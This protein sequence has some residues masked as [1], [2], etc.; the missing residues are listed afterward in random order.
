MGVQITNMYSAFGEATDKIVNGKKSVFQLADCCLQ[1]VIA[2]DVS[3]SH[4]LAATSCPDAIAPSLGQCL[5]QAYNNVFHS[6]H[7]IDIVQGCAG[8][9]SAMILAS[10]LAEANRSNVVVITSDA[11]Q[12]ATSTAS[13]VYHVF[14]NGVFGCCLSYSNSNKRLIHHQSRQYK[15]LYEVVTI[16]LGHDSDAIISDNIE[17]MSSDPRKHLGLKLNNMLAL[18]LMRNAEDFYIDFTKTTGHPDI[19]ILHQ[20]NE[21]LI[22]HLENVF[23]KYPVRFINMAA[24][25]GNCGCATTGIV[26]NSI[27]DKI[28]NKKVMLC[29]FGTGGVITAGLWQC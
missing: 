25:T 18:K 23:S 8:G 22:K 21:V 7:T 24:E 3:Y 16:G 12:K 5:N 6:A 17:D 10:Q 19:L 20:V 27:I 26:L 11:A 4:L 2:E 9:V 28:E 15:D 14:K 1:K 29:S 13:E